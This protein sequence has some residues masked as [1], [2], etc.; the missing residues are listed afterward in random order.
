MS[1]E[2]LQRLFDRLYIDQ[3]GNFI[4][5]GVELDSCADFVDLVN[6]LFEEEFE[7]MKAECTGYVSFVAAERLLEGGALI[8]VESVDDLNEDRL[9]TADIYRMKGGELQH[10]PES[11]EFHESVYDSFAEA[12]AHKTFKVR[13]RV[14]RYKEDG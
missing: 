1:R 9:L 7:E 2:K 8:R 12:V 14:E 10:S 5:T 11:D 4:E 6:E 3:D 13:F